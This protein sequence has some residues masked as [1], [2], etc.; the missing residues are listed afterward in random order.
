MDITKLDIVLAELGCLILV[1]V[2]LIFWVGIINADEVLFK[3][4]IFI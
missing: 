4:D 3:F 1:N 2:I